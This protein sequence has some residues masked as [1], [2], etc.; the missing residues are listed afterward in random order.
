MKIGEKIRNARED[1]DLSQ[2]E[3]AR[4]IPMNQSS[5]SKIERD[6]QEPNLEQLRKICQIL[7]LNPSYLLALGEFEDSVLLDLKFARE[8]KN[9][10][11]KN[12]K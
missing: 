1:L 8:V 12:F 5:Y 2:E 6:I 4:C 9:C 11:K 10:Y 7:K 3:V